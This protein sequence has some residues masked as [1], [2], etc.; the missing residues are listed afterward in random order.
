[1]EVIFAFLRG[2]KKYVPWE[3]T[4]KYGEMSREVINE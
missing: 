4:A 1:M 2:I 3:S